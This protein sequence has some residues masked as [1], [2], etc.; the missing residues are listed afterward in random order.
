VDLESVMGRFLK[1]VLF[2]CL[3]F[4]VPLASAESFHVSQSG[5][6]MVCGGVTQSTQAISFVNSSINWA[7]PKVA[8]KIGPGDTVYLCGTITTWII[9]SGSGSNGA[10]ITFTKH[11][12]DPVKTAGSYANGNSYIDFKGVSLDDELEVTDPTLSNLAAFQVYNNGAAVPRHLNFQYL[13]IH[14]VGQ[15]QCFKGSSVSPFPDYI[16]VLDSHIEFCAALRPTT[17]VDRNGN[18]GTCVPGSGC[19]M[20]GAAIGLSSAHS[21]YRNLDV[22]HTDDNIYPSG[23]YTT[24]SKVN[25]HD[26]CG[27]LAGGGWDVTGNKK[28]CEPDLVDSHSPMHIDYVQPTAGIQSASANHILTE[29]G[30]ETKIYA[31]AVT[32]DLETIRSNDLSATNVTNSI[33]TSTA[34]S[35]TYADVDILHRTA[36]TGTGGHMRVTWFKCISVSA[37]ICTADRN[38]TDGVANATS[39][40]WSQWQSPSGAISRSW[41]PSGGT[42]PADLAVTNATRSVISSASYSFLS[43]D[44]GRM[45]HLQFGTNIVPGYYVCQSVASGACTVDR[46]ATNGTN[47]TGIYGNLLTRAENAHLGV[48][49]DTVT[50][51]AGVLT[52]DSS[53]KTIT[54]SSGSFIT[55]GYVIGDT[56]WITGTTSNNGWYTVSNVTALVITVNETMTTETS[57]STGN[58]G[59]CAGVKGLGNYV[60]RYMQIYNIGGNGAGMGVQQGIGAITYT[61]YNAVFYNNTFAELNRWVELT[62]KPTDGVNGFANFSK[63]GADVNNV[64][65]NSM[66]NNG[67]WLGLTSGD[68]TIDYRGGLVFLDSRFCGGGSCSYRFPLIAGTESGP[69]RTYGT[70]THNQGVGWTTGDP[71]FINCGWVGSVLNCTDLR[72]R[73]GSAAT[74]GAVPLTT[75][76]ASDGGGALLTVALS[77]STSSASPTA[78]TGG[79]DFFQDGQ[80]GTV[81]PDCVIIIHADNSHDI[82]CIASGGIIDRTHMTLTSSPPRA[83]GDNIFLYSNAF[84]DVKWSSLYPG[85]RGA[86]LP[87]AILSFTA[88][89]GAVNAGISTTLSWSTTGTSSCSLDN[90]YGSVALNG[91]VT[92]LPWKTTTYTLSCDTLTTTYTVFVGSLYKQ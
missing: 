59:R 6:S 51:Y 79:T 50:V 89:P 67:F 38:I 71:K 65:T 7:N 39:A 42:H 2:V 22:S 11:A 57:T 9:Y 55:D 21:I 63:Y 88:L 14:E 36:T 15:Q 56:V 43:T 8:G 44:V 61:Y 81:T 52:I 73:V 31:L 77:P 32:P 66:G 37:G 29:D 20:G 62:S 45:F 70:R 74:V 78:T 46:N 10:S 17:W 84:G 25:F 69:I 72:L 64:Y 28:L 19:G 76:D 75:V 85:V 26:Y 47:A 3:C 92:I 35:F 86:T 24:I 33:V 18:P 83:P 27:S 12:G 91:S 60:L 58:I 49:Q 13:W 30:S 82:A 1:S 54:R 40:Q 41:Y 16:N 48:W 4:L 87:F 80:D 90:G 34:Y 5:G 53:T 68:P 23:S